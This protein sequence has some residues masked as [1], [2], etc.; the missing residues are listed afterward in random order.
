M[1]NSK[2]QV[3]SSKTS[4]KHYLVNSNRKSQREDLMAITSNK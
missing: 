3:V 2:L 1:V 4:S